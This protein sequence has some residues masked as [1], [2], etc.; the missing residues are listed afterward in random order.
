MKQPI[1]RFAAIAL[2]ALVAASVL[3]D[4]AGASVMQFSLPA[5]NGYRLQVKTEGGQAL[6]SLN[7]SNP[8]ATATRSGTGFRSGGLGTSRVATYFVSDAVS[9]DAIDADLGPL[10][11]IHV[12]FTPSGRTRVVHLHRGAVPAGCR[13]PRRLLHRL[14]SFE[15]TISFHGENGFASVDATR[16]SGTTGP[17]ARRHCEPTGVASRAGAPVPPHVEH[18]WV[19]TD[20]VF[21]ARNPSS[22]AKPNATWLLAWTTGTGVRYLAQRF[23]VVRPGL[24]IQRTVTVAGPKAGFSCSGDLSTATL[25]PPAPFSGEATYSDRSGRLTGDLAIELPGSGPEPLAGPA[26]EAWI[27][28]TR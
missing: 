8:V 23:E 21:S 1:A 4:P 9:A 26:F 20:T 25:R 22:R 24:A 15:G 11:E 2:L 5:S 12:Q 7:R 16:V 6:V 14:G 27:D 3:A 28:A 17:S 13:A 10:G 18:V 19:L